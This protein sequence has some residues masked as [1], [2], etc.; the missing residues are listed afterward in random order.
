MNARVPK[1]WHSRGYL[2]HFDSPERIQHVTFR[3][4]ASLPKT[5]AEALS[6]D[7][8]ARVRQIEEYLDRCEGERPLAN[9]A[10]ARIVENAVRHFDGERF[11]LFA[12]VIMP[13]HVHVVLDVCARFS[14]GE[15]VRGWKAFS[16]AQIN[17]ATGA[18]G[19]FW[20][21]DYFD[22]YLRD[23]D[24]LCRTVDY[25]ER[26]PVAAGLVP[27]PEQWRWSSARARRKGEMR[28]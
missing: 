6:P 10:L 13:N 16:A 1:G 25:V 3:T 23:E 11:R 19:A 24:D 8:K 21:R 7:A 9:P 18:S 28:A 20:A 12:W 22:R 17:R 14:I 27:A 5:V 2:P 15:V 4:A 26:N